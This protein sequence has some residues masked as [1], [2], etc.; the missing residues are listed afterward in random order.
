MSKGDAMVV[1][2]DEAARAVSLFH[3]VAEDASLRRL[4]DGLINDT[5]AVCSG[6]RDLVLQRVH[7]LF[8]PEVHINIAAATNHLRDRGFPAPELC[9]SALD[10]LPWVELEGKVWRLM[11]RLPGRSVEQVETQAQAEVGARAFARFHSA[12]F[13]VAFDFIAFHTDVHDT[14]G[15]LRTLETCLQT[16][17]GHRLY[18][19]LAPLAE[20]IL[21]APERVEVRDSLPKRIVHG[22]PKIGNVLFGDDGTITGIIDFD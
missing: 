14:A 1:T 11:T 2:N 7:E 21:R 16:H 19:E 10:N 17:R 3:G 15:H 9:L 20:A 8:Q 5:F 13:D 12:L 4:G 18:D 22:D 6:E